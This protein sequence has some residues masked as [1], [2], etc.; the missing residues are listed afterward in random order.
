MIYT[1]VRF[2][3]INDEI[4][5]IVFFKIRFDIGIYFVVMV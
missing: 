4:G 2:I 5:L 1:G 3:Y